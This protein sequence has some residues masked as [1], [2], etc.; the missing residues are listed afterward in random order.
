MNTWPDTD[1]KIIAGYLGRL[2]LRYP[3]S[4]IYYRQALHSFQEVAVRQQR[5]TS[6]VSRKVLEVWLSERALR[7]GRRFYIALASSIAS[8][9]SSPWPPS[10]SSISWP[11]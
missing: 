1:G 4:P 7:P 10:L 3:I 9:T 11:L 6:Q 8:S 5:Q 2:R